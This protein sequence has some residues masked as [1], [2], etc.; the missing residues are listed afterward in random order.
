MT[1]DG[2]KTEAALQF[3]TSVLQKL[4][5]KMTHGLWPAASR[6]NPGMRDC[7]ILINSTNRCFALAAAKAITR[8][9]MR[10][11]FEHE[12]S[13]DAV[14]GS[15]HVG[16]TFG[17]AVLEKDSI[18]QEK[19]MFFIQTPDRD[20]L[21]RCLAYSLS[22]KPTSYL[23]R[24]FMGVVRYWI[25][26]QSSFTTLSKFVLQAM[27][28]PAS[29]AGSERHSSVVNR[30]MTNDRKLLER[31]NGRHDAFEVCFPGLHV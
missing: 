11:V 29:S 4:D 28:I 1:L 8:M 22:T 27:A 16:N 10:S 12:N 21:G 26:H 23:K 25:D 18:C 13:N 2:T 24:D 30:L 5:D 31:Y 15:S 6:L 14:I 7:S 19:F 9:M 20:K 17:R 3:P